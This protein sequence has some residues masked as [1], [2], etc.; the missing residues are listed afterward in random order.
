M[1]AYYVR[2]WS[3]WLELMILARTIK[4]VVGL[5]AGLVHLRMNTP[6]L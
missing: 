6:M 2:N 5:K 3:D 4:K 1:D